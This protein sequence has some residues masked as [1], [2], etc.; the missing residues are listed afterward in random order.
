MKMKK[1][2]SLL[3]AASL[4]SVSFAA[5]GNQGSSGSDN[6]NAAEMLD[7]SNMFITSQSQ[8]F[9]KTSYGVRYICNLDLVT[10]EEKPQEEVLDVE[11]SLTNKPV[12]NV[13]IDSNWGVEGDTVYGKYDDTD[14]LYKVTVTGQKTY[15]VTPWISAEAVNNSELFRDS[16]YSH[17]RDLKCFQPDGE[18]VF[19]L[20]GLNR[21]YQNKHKEI[22]YRI[23]RADK[24][25]KE[26]HFVG[27]E[28]VRAANMVVYDGWIYYSDNGY[29]GGGIQKEIDTSRVG[30]YKI[31]TDGSEKTR[32]LEGGEALSS[33]ID[34]WF[35][36]LSVYKNKLYFIDLRKGSKLCRMNFDGSGLEQLSKGE[37]DYFTV[38][39]ATD[40][41]YYRESTYYNYSSQDNSENKA[42]S[43]YRVDLNTKE[44]KQLEQVQL[45]E[46]T[47]Y[48]CANKNYL[49]FGA[50][51]HFARMY[52]NIK[53]M[54][55][56]SG[57]VMW[58]N[59]DL[60]KVDWEDENGE[61]HS[62]IKHNTIRWSECTDEKL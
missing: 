3:L 2:I 26:I 17:I 62:E 8:L 48:L 60:Q 43:V 31:R 36:N 10:E 42:V 45:R 46:K 4:L 23:A 52:D 25:G 55:L 30:L 54:D 20:V 24:A 21:E 57:K 40:T 13:F 35:G 39:E 16:S 59:H 6:S 38:D 34:Y 5:C 53:R 56:T 19:C 44:A 15:S 51:T 29:I 27:D 18:D 11:T 12:H 47:M 41:L 58:L 61:L 1:V 22:N 7:K 9:W 32:L 50:Y 49:Y 14:F 37:A 33:E 28:N